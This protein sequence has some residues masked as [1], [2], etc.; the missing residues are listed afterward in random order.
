[1]RFQIRHENSKRSGGGRLR[2]HIFVP[3]MSYEDA[4]GYEYQLGLLEGVSFVKVYEKTNDAVIT[5]SGCREKLV[6]KLR[7]FKYDRSA[8]PEEVL[9]YSGRETSAEYKE[10]LITKVAVR[11]LRRVF[12]P[13]PV[14]YILTGIRAA[15]YVGKGLGCLAK[16]KIEVPVLDATAIGVSF[17]RGDIN[18]AGSV[19]FLLSVG[20]LLEEWTHKKS[21]GDLARV[22]SLN[23]G[24]VWLR[25]GAP[26]SCGGDILMD[27]SEIQKGDLIVVRMGTVIP[28][29]GEVVHGEAMVDQASMTGES[30]PVKKDSGDSVFAGTVITEGELVIKV[31]EAEGGSRYER[32]VKMIEDSEKLKSGVES[33]AEH[34]ADR[35]VPYALGAT[36]LTCLITRNMTKA[37]SVLM[38]DYSCAL[39]LAMPVTVLSA[40]REARLSDINVKGGKFFESIS[41]ADMIVF[42]KTGT[43]TKAA[44]RVKEVVSFCEETPDELLRIAACI[45]EHFPHTIA[46]AVV[47]AAEDK[48]L[49]HDEMHS[50][51][52]YIVAHGIVTEIEGKRTVIGSHH[53]IFTDEGCRVPDNRRDQYDA[54]PREYS[55]LYL[56]ID[57]ML[58]AVILIED[59]LREEA[60]EVI[61]ALKECGFSS[62]IMMT[63]DSR[64]TAKSIA[65]RIG[66]DEYYAEVLPEDKAGYVEK[67]RS[68]GHKVIMVG[69]GINDSPALSAAD[70]GIAIS[71]GAE[72]AREIADITISA[73]DL[74]RVVTL[75]KLSRLLMKRIDG[76][77][78]FIMGFNSTL[79]IL[80]IL[81]ILPPATAALLHNSSTIAITLSGTRKLLDSGSECTE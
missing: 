53:F 61:S 64:R 73:D 58:K 19:M 20:E 37:M 18:T 70:V 24:K 2:I 56:A 67:K 39:K 9:K 26:D 71:S 80:G 50:K 32:I 54:L 13:F 40:I 15:G 3:R 66:V 62:V 22:M 59:P 55:H 44:P 28:F 34:L 35:L 1:M 47:R 36:A 51:V 48:G 6:K 14:R 57:G 79:I 81:G 27:A 68:E 49:L 25:Q 43:L 17:L 7:H 8:V 60:P 30:E 23:V 11:Y 69:D 31:R 10:K 21:V 77:Y 5:Y 33:R 41:D 52:E 72:I 75:K 46:Q 4:D 74:Y 42:D 63:G 45:E 16:R 38:V 29:D 12:L 78:R 76:N 65:D